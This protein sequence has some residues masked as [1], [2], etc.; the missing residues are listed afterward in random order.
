MTPLAFSST[1]EKKAQAMLTLEQVTVD[2]C[3]TFYQKKQDDGSHTL[4][5]QNA[6]AGVDPYV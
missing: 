6:K 2:F 5:S 3:I 1:P 4:L